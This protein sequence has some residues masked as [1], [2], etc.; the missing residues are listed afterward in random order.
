MGKNHKQM[1]F[2]RLKRNITKIVRDV[3]WLFVKPQ[4][5]KNLQTIDFPHDLPEHLQ[6][7][8]MPEAKY[9]PLYERAL[10]LAK[11]LNELGHHVLV[12][13][14][15][16][17][18]S[19]CAVK[20]G[21]KNSKVNKQNGDDQCLQ[22]ADEANRLLGHY[23]LPSVDLRAFVTDEIKQELEVELDSLPVDLKD[24]QYQGV[25]WGQL[26]A[27]EIALRKK[28]SNLDAVRA[29]YPDLWRQH[30]RDNL[31]TY[32]AACQLIKQLDV[33]A[34]MQF[35][36]YS[37]H[38]AAQCAAS[39][40]KVPIYHIDWP[41][42]KDVDF[43]RYNIYREPSLHAINDVRNSWPRW[44][45]AA[46]STARVDEISDDLVGRL[47]GGGVY[48]YSPAKTH[49]GFQLLKNLGLSDHKKTL[50]A[51][52]SSLDEHLASKLKYTA[53][54]NKLADSE[55]PFDD[56][57]QWLQSLMTYCKSHNDLQLIVRVHPR[58][59]R[60]HRDS[61]RSDHLK[62]LQDAFEAV[63][64]NCRFIWPEEPTSSYDLAEVAD[65]A[66]TSWS[67]IGLELAR[68]GIPVLSAFNRWY[69]PL[70]VDD[71]ISWAS[72]ENAYYKTLE[73]LLTQK[74]DLQRIARAF[75]WYN[76]INLET[77]LD[78]SDVVPAERSHRAIPFRMP[79]RAGALEKAIIQHT[80][81][82]KINWE[83]AEGL[84]RSAGA[85]EGESVSL[86]RHLRRMIHYIFTGADESLP[87]HL[88]VS[89]ENVTSR[90]DPS[91]YSYAD[92]ASKAFLAICGNEVEYRI[93][94]KTWK[95]FSSLV[96]RIAP[97]C[98]TEE[99][100]NQIRVA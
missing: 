74:G 55:Q 73:L 50:V 13:R 87:R 15:F 22:C 93:G 19:H 78:F 80:P 100:R 65:I 17:L 36:N 21:Q 83:D 4:V 44:R 75:R 42:H 58:E 18:Y 38:G 77:G 95:R 86:R 59:G 90:F 20:V 47:K 88:C 68:L 46:I 5:R 85:Q 33:A 57:I 11:T 3:R 45:E 52:T 35:C 24:Y 62:K 98:A 37:I 54:Q 91:D 7:F 10:Y 1:D 43:Q 51:Y 60:N 2:N 81:L 53:L 31:M 6:L 94:Q 16:D 84:D 26:A 69:V 76:L 49:G 9:D 28:L 64:G 97:L 82:W 27:S 48:S 71:F 79:K 92:D 40:A 8:F 63:D 66:L 41:G 14:C 70:P 99:T 25:L 34:W 23:G 32:L 89:H 12:V 39:N 30:V 56:Q 61:V 96:S 29:E 67:T 72:T